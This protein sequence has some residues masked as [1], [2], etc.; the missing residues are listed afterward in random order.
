MFARCDTGP[1]KAANAAQVNTAIAEFNKQ[2]RETCPAG[3]AEEV[4]NP[5]RSGQ[6]SAISGMPARTTMIESGRPSRQ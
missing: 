5:A 4:T 3:A 6:N 1:N 2:M